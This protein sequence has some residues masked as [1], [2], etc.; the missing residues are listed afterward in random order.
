MLPTELDVAAATAISVA[1]FYLNSANMMMNNQNGLYSDFIEN[2][3]ALCNH[4][5]YHHVLSQHQHHQLI[6]VP[7]EII[8]HK[9]GIV[10]DDKLEQHRSFS[11]RDFYKKENNI[12]LSRR[13][14]N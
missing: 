13:I 6:Q 2:N 5:T 9:R 3:P 12:G 8:M 10:A 14:V 11:K 4:N 7:F 1:D